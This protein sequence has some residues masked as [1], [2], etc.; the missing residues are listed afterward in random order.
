MFGKQLYIAFT[1]LVGFLFVAQS[2]QADSGLG[3]IVS[4]D[5]EEV[6]VRV[7]GEIDYWPVARL[8]QPPINIL[9]KDSSNF[10][11]IDTTDN[12]AVWVSLSYITTDHQA[13]LKKNCQSQQLAS[14]EDKKQF[15]VRGIGE[16]C[17]EE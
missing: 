14:S 15:G 12:G 2:L 3:R 17:E 9:E 8:G 4:F 1:V 7:N 5:D 13:A 11:R 10:V 16:S 6:E